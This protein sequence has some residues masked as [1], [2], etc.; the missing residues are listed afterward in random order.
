MLPDLGLLELVKQ[1]NSG[2]AWG[3]RTGDYMNGSVWK[4]FHVVLV[5]EAYVTRSDKCCKHRVKYPVLLQ[6]TQNIPKNLLR[7][8]VL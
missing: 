5:H 2:N 4:R 6:I 3:I 1:Q 8:A 7:K